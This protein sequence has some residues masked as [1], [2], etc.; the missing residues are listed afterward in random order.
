VPLPVVPAEL[1]PVDAV[2]PLL[3]LEVAFVRMNDAPAPDPVGVRDV[4]PDVVDP[5][6]VPVAP[7]VLVMSARCRHP[8]TVSIPVC[9]VFFALVC[10][11]GSVVCALPLSAATTAAHANPTANIAPTRFIDPSWIYGHGL[12]CK[13]VATCEGDYG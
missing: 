2:E 5:P 9:I 1:V 6:V 3:L 7:V 10:C 12:G 8:T 13:A 11:D 4:V